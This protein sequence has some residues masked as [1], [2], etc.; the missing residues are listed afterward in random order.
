MASSASSSDSSAPAPTRPTASVALASYNGATFIGAQIDSILAQT[1]LPDEIVV[2]DDQSSDDTLGVLA[3][4]AADSPVPIRVH[5]NP[6]RLGYARN[7]GRAASLCR[8][9]LIFFCDQD[10]LWAPT[11]VERMKDAFA[12]PA[13]LL[14]FHGAL[15]VSGEDEAL[16]QLYR[17]EEQRALLAT[18]P[19]DPWYASYGL[20][21]VFRASLR[22]NDDLWERALNH[23]HRENELLAHDQWYYFL[24]QI[25][26]RIAYIDEPLV[27]YRQHGANTVGAS[28][29]AR[30][31]GMARLRQKFG[32][33]ARTD[34][35]R[36][37]AALRR[38]EILEQIRRRTSGPVAERAGLLGECYRSLAERLLRRHATYTRPGI[39]QRTA[40]FAGMLAH[41]DYGP[42]PWRFRPRSILRD[43]IRGVIGHDMGSETRPPPGSKA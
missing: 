9:E 36:A 27:R 30:P 4:L 21:Q 40:R 10:D 42:Q 24:A 28:Q 31:S 41:L 14:A 25:F 29:V 11:K 34:R 6:E 32:H 2:T 8:S 38:V 39:G 22:A 16:Y 20:T 19:I 1:E 5:R 43:L 7:F 33:D 35:L 26:G 13:V 3:A 12:D 18:Q 37:Q 15:V 17:A 23:V